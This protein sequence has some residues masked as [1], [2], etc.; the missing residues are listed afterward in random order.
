MAVTRYG[1]PIDQA[2]ALWVLSAIEGDAAAVAALK[3]ADPRDPRAGRPD[4]RPR[5][6]P[7]RHRGLHQAR[8]QEAA[9][10]RW[11][12]SRTS[13]RWPTTPTPGV[14]RELILALRWLPTAQVGGALKALARAWDGQD[15]W[16]LEALGLALQDRESSYLAELFDGTL[17]GDL[18]LEKAGQDGHVALPPYF[19]ADRNEAYISAGTPDLPANPLSKTL[20]LAWRLH[21]PEVAAAARQDLPRRW[22]PPSC[23]RRPTTSCSRSPTR[24]PPCSWPSRPSRRSTRRGR[25][26]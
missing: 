11:P 1:D 21:R 8:G 9:R 15:R 25:S 23:S 16:Y 24:R 26:P 20:G 3:D 13:C 4:P 6:Q 7:G 5:P 18:D 17:F 19:P 14:R 22:P 2:R 10:R 12:T